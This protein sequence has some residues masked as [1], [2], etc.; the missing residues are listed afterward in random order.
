[1]QMPGMDGIELAHRIKGDEALSATRLI[2]LS[3]L[4]YPGPEAR[5][6]GIEVTLLKP[7]RE[8]LL[9]DAAAKVLGMSRPDA[10]I[11]PV[12]AKRPA[13]R[14]DARVLVAEDNAVNQKV[15]TMMLRRLGIEPG[16]APD[17]QA[18]LEALARERFDLILMDIQMPKLSGHEAT[19]SIR[20]AEQARGEGEHI[21]IVAMTAGV[22]ERDRDECSAAGMDDFIS[23][24]AQLTELEA[25]LLR[26]L[27]GH[28]IGPIGHLP[29][30]GRAAQPIDPHTA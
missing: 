21:P 20:A 5:R 16:I 22:S 9:H 27:P 1:M 28:V 12:P 10:G 17:G 6:V 11:V 3:S 23:K 29:A 4:G 13:R 15:V 26:W 18:A 24:P 19:C 8:I 2:M 25:V 14:F 7:V 30:A